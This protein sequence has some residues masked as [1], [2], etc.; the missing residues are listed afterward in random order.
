MNRPVHEEPLLDA[1]VRIDNLPPEGRDLDVIATP[2]QGEAIARQ[3]AISAVERLEARIK[4]TKFRG[5][6]RA[7]GRLEAV[8]VQPC[9]VS[10]EPVRQLIDEEFERIYLPAEEQLKPAPAH[11]EV[12]VDLDSDELPD[13]FEG[14]EVDLADAIIEA[15]ALALDPYPRAEG[16]SLEATGLAIEEETSPFASLKSLLDPDG[17]G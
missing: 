1:S 9:V 5:G 16:A 15:V 12:F 8:T 14:H 13:Y 3:L 10:F 11:P 4:V 6:L 7:H 2:A 17:K